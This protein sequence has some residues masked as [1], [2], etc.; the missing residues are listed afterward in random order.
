MVAIVT[1]KKRQAYLSPPVGPCE[2]D[3]DNWQADGLVSFIPLINGIARDLGPF[4]LD[5]QWQSTNGLG[6]THQ[7]YTFDS[8][9]DGTRQARYFYGCPGIRSRDSGERFYRSAAPSEGDIEPRSLDMND[10][11]IAAFCGKFS[12]SGNNPFVFIGDMN[13]T[14][15]SDDSL[16]IDGNSSEKWRSQRRATGT[17][18][19]SRIRTTLSDAYTVDDVWPVV[20]SHKTGE[21]N[22]H[23]VHGVDPRTHLEKSATGDLSS[24]D[25]ISSEFNGVA[26]GGKLSA[27]ETDDNRFVSFFRLWNH[28]WGSDEVSLMQ[29]P[30]QRFALLWQRRKTI[31]IPIPTATIP[32]FHHHY[33]QMRVH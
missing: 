12:G 13:N 24:A 33:N 27:W 5:P 4:K 25:T 11:S 1:A 8:P 28:A 21:S 2:L 32:R 20:V 19:T 29:E 26:L 31:F 30:D 17:G 9:A 16:T 15:N 6:N 22:G 18:A 14:A 10:C 7:S 3:R 23:F